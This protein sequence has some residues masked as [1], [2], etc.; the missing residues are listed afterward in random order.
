MGWCRRR[1]CAAGCTKQFLFRLFSPPPRVAPPWR[2]ATLPSLPHPSRGVRS[3]RASLPPC[4][5]GVLPQ[6]PTRPFLWDPRRTLH[7]PARLCASFT[8]SGSL[9]LRA[10]GTWRKAPPDPLAAHA[11]GA[12]LPG[13]CG[14]F[15]GR[16]GDP[17]RTRT[18]TRKKRR[19][20]SAL[21]TILPCLPLRLLRGTMP[22]I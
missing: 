11:S 9:F 22:P 1:R 13:G 20:A 17:P 14:S 12:L 16:V 4:C 2:T 6:S 18:R 15:R 3:G 7:L 19:R 8:R 10:C 21:R 5:R